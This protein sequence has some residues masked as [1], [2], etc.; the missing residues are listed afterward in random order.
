MGILTYNC[1]L[2][3]SGTVTVQGFPSRILW[4]P[5]VQI[6]LATLEISHKKG[7]K[8]RCMNVEIVAH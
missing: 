6:I 5:K 1:I 3:F 2:N 4:G 8:H 7:V